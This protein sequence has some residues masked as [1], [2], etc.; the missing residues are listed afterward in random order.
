M[1]AERKLPLDFGSMPGTTRQWN[2]VREILQ[3]DLVNIPAHCVW[4]IVCKS[5][6]TKMAMMPHYEAVSDNFNVHKICT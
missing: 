4:N 1:V 6:I 5:T 3:E 2:S